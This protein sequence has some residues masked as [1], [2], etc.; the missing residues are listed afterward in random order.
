MIS[1]FNRRQL[2]RGLVLLLAGIGTMG[3]VWL[4]CL[5]GAEIVHAFTPNPTFQ[6]RN[7]ATGVAVILAAVGAW[8]W[9]SRGQGAQIF[10]DHAFSEALNLD[11]ATSQAN[12]SDDV[13]V[14]NYRDIF[15]Q[16][17]FIGPSLLCSGVAHWL[18]RM[19]PNPELEARM[20]TVLERIRATKK[21]QDA[22]HY[23][24]QAEEV[25]A[26]IRCGLVD[27]SPSKLRL[28]VA[29]LTPEP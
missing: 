15:R 2:I 11:M 1:E 13:D 8:R 12:E 16:V 26:L 5:F 25:A 9:Y 23:R 14:A 22:H 29:G 7:F 18:S 20:V 24:D 3:V 28:K 10:R 17:I 21:W 6:P 27:F 4:V 19:K